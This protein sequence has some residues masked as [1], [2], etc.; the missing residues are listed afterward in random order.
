MSCP[1]AD[2][3]PLKKEVNGTVIL[4]PLVFPVICLLWFGQQKCNEGKSSASL[5]RQVAARFSDM[6]CNF[7]SVKNHII[8]NYSETTK[9][10]EKIST[11]L[12]FLESNIF[13]DACFIQFKNNKK[14]LI[15]LA[16]DFY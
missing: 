11:Y 15:K 2:S 10:R 8:A 14:N 1:T 16:T 3:K 13:F 4:P 6:F 9:A 7:Y 5:G 12:V